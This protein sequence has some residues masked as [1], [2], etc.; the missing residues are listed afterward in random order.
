MVRGRDKDHPNTNTSKELLLR[1][2]PRPLKYIE[3]IILSRLNLLLAYFDN[4]G[5]IRRIEA[6]GNTPGSFRSA[7]LSK[8]SIAI[9][10]N[11]H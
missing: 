1:I 4:L 3:D 8:A 2:D 10:I 6:F 5:Y 9:Y 11:N 7:I